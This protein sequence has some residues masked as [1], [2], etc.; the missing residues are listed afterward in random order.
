M[1]KMTAMLALLLVQNSYA[2]EL[3]GVE[4]VEILAINGEKVV[5]TVFSDQKK[6]N[7]EAGVHQ[8]VIRYEKYF[9]DE[10]RTALSRPVIF[11]I[12][13]QQD[14]TIS[15]G[16][17]NTLSKAERAIN[18]GLTWTISDAKQ[19]YT[20]NDATILKSSGFLPYSDIEG[21]IETYNKNNNIII[22]SSAKALSATP[23]S[24][25]TIV[26]TTAAIQESTAIVTNQAAATSMTIENCSGMDQIALYQQ[27]TLAQKKAFRL[28]LLEQDLK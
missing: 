6:P 10:N 8:I 23:P 12:D 15:A 24:Q 26:G 11:N 21:L 5:N 22:A 19:Q 18:E 25:P 2:L 9:D 13:L 28:W 14:I 17:Y 16:Y 27:S 3:K 4:G 7:I 1:K 20:V